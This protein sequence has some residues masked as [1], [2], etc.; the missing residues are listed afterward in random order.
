VGWLLLKEQRVAGVSHRRANRVTPEFRPRM[1]VRPQTVAPGTAC[2]SIQQV[3]AETTSL[4]P[5]VRWR[6]QSLQ[7]SF[8]YR[9]TGS[10]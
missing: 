9:P 10:C 5:D 8:F 3:I 6:W 4:T 7:F 2:F 1:L